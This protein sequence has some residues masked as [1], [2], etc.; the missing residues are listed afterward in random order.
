MSEHHIVN[1]ILPG[2]FVLDIGANSGEKAEWYVKRGIRVVCV[3]P[4][5]DMIRRL[6]ARFSGNPTVAIVGKALG[7]EVGEL[8]MSICSES[9]TISTLDEGWKQ[10]RFADQKWDSTVMVQV[11]T[12][13]LIVAEFG[14]PRYTKIDVEGY[15]KQVLSGLSARVGI[16][17]FE[18]TSEYIANAFDIVGMLVR[19]G[20]TKFNV[21][22]AEDPH[23]MLPQWVPFHSLI[24]QLSAL[25]QKDGDAWGDIYAN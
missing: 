21:S 5:P 10:G 14:V 2:D 17:S 8:P 6:N 19:L 18:F 20:Y 23:F 13:D 3:E 24:L 4:Q 7:A 1:S 15:E 12:L 16:V 22:T 9:P 25:C 11:S